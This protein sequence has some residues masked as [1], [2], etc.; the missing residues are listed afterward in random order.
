MHVVVALVAV[1]GSA[2]DIGAV[3]LLSRHS[4]GLASVCVHARLARV[5]LVA[6]C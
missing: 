1:S 4:H 2:S 3:A 5:E 6:L